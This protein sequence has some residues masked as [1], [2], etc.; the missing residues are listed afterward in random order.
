MSLSSGAEDK[1]KIQYLSSSK[2]QLKHCESKIDCNFSGRQTVTGKYEV[3]IYAASE[4]Y[5]TCDQFNETCFELNFYPSNKNKL[6]HF[7]GYKPD[8][9]NIA[10]KVEAL[11][12]LTNPQILEQISHDKII[13]LSGTATVILGNYAMGIACDHGYAFA[14]I[15]KVKTKSAAKI[16]DGDLGGC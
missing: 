14:D 16:K 13:G 12:Q 8:Y 2:L 1:L 11:R 4:D 5:P 9:I 7:A 3:I 10:N 6:P 15:V